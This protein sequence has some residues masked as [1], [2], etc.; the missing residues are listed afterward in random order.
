MADKKQ[1][2]A[3]ST[4][5]DK[6]QAPPPPKQTNVAE[7]LLA[8]VE[9]AVQAPKNHGA[10]LQLEKILGVESQDTRG[11]YRALEQVQVLTDE[12]EAALERLADE[13]HRELYIEALRTIRSTFLIAN[14]HSDPNF[15]QHIRKEDIQSLKFAALLLS[16]HHPESVIP[17]GELDSI[18]ELLNE[19][20]SEV[21][22]SSLADEVKV[23][24]R[25]A[26][27]ELRTS[28]Y[29]YDIRG[30]GALRKGLAHSVGIIVTNAEQLEQVENK[31]E[32]AATMS[33]L[34][35][36]WKLV[37][38]GVSFAS[39]TQRLIEGASKFLPVV[40]RFFS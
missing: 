4:G 23:I 11:F 9:Q 6:A 31:P 12:V 40:E 26:I 29:N 32:V 21:R 7:R 8:I 35:K 15:S 17:K 20:D 5:N 28:I 30:V 24:F 3:S 36:A 2:S 34:G 18:I 10:V 25:D 39:N 33:K 38:N 1:E 13:G 14:L 27:N 22:A 19:L 37:S 16:K